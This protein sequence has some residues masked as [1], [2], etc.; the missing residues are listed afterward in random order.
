M[1]F[2]TIVSDIKVLASPP[3]DQIEKL[4]GGHL[5][6]ITCVAHLVS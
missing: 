6:E 1:H 3:T 4:S 2:A 5:Y